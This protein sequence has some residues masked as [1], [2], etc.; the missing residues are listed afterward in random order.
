MKIK[1]FSQIGKRTNNE[2]F[3]GFND[4]VVTVCDGMGGHT[5]GEVASRFVVKNI[6]HIFSDKHKELSK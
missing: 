3:I 5:S 1:S 6:L 4:N 2:D